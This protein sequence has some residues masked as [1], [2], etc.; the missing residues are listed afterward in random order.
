MSVSQGDD[1]H[2]RPA[3]DG[4]G[5]LT[6]HP[7]HLLAPGVA[8]FVMEIN[9][10]S[11]EAVAEMIEYQVKTLDCHCGV[12]QAKENENITHFKNMVFKPLGFKALPKPLKINSR[13][14]KEHFRK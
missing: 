3:G 9:T 7:R 4:G 5:D 8:V 13:F 6:Q 1:V 2:D 14:M 12:L 10:S 11:G